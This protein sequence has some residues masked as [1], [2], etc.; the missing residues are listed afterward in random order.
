MKL[1]NKRNLSI[2]SIT[3]I[4]AI[5]VLASQ[6]AE[7]RG[8][9]SG[10]KGPP[11]GAYTACET[12][13]EGVECSM[14]GRKGDVLTGTCEVKRSDKLVCVPEGHQDRGSRRSK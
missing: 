10:R 2:L 11:P 9:K 5:I 7:A 12:K 8:E 14:E 4:S 6:S 1:F 13:A 3:A